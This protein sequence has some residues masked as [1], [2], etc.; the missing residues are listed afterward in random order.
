MNRVY[1]LLE[2]D[3]TMF[4]EEDLESAESAV[5]VIGVFPS[6]ERAEAIKAERWEVLEGDEG[7][8]LWIEEHEVD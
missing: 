6:E 5:G 4:D 3:V 2:Y 8:H 1:V 7:I